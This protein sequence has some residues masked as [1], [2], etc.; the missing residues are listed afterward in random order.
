MWGTGLRPV[1]PLAT[2]Q[3]PVASAWLPGKVGSLVLERRLCHGP[4][5]AHMSF[6]LPS[7]L[8]GRQGTMQASPTCVGSEIHGSQRSF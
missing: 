6:S 1:W 5:D 8:S 4:W 7:G 2:S 3:G